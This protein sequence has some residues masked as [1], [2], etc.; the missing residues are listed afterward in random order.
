MEGEER[1]AKHFALEEASDEV[2]SGKPVV[3]RRPAAP[4]NQR[5]AKVIANSIVASHG[6]EAVGEAGGS[7]FISCV[8]IVRLPVRFRRAMAAARGL[9]AATT[10]SGP[11]SRQFHI[12]IIRASPVGMVEPLCEVLHRSYVG[13]DKRP[14]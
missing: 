8:G 2:A 14:A 7:A 13:T 11:M 10:T 3:A 4:D 6:L 9:T 1:D 5:V 12:R